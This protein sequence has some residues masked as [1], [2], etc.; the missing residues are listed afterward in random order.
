M[1]RKSLTPSPRRRRPRCVQGITQRFRMGH[2]NL[3]ITV[4]FGD[5]GMPFEVFGNLGKAG[6]CDSAS[7]EGLTHL[8]SLALQL[9]APVP[10]IVKKLRGISCC[11]CW[12][13][14]ILVKS[15]PEALALALERNSTSAVLEEVN[16]PNLG[17]EESKPIK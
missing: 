16:R 11:P 9:G 4:N 6:G 12:E 1:V 15:I 14:G 13:D 7:I 3:Y 2:G 8:V 5:D 17:D 10:R